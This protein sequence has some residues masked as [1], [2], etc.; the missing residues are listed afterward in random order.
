MDMMDEAALARAAAELPDLDV[1]VFTPAG[2]R[3]PVHATGMSPAQ[4]SAGPAPAGPALAF[5]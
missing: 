2:R 1:L 3:R 5:G 4:G